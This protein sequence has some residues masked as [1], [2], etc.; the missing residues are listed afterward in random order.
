MAN[1]DCQVLYIGKDHQTYRGVNEALRPMGLSVMWAQDL[2]SARMLAKTTRMEVLVCDKAMDNGS[3]KLFRPCTIQ[4]GASCIEMD[5]PS[6]DP[7]GAQFEDNLSRTMK[8]IKLM[9]CLPGI[10]MQGANTTQTGFGR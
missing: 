9:H 7:T 6:P 8:L 10:Q 5:L 1:K 3:K 4:P 2:E